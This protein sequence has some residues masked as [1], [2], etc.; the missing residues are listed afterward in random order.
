MKDIYKFHK[1]G[2]SVVTTDTTAKAIMLQRGI[3]DRLRKRSP[4]DTLSFCIDDNHPTHWLYCA[5]VMD[6]PDPPENGYM[7][8]AWPKAEFDLSFVRAAIAKQLGM[9]EA[10]ITGA[11]EVPRKSSS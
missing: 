11:F 6:H 9:L 7:V 4:S 1:S 10:E 8:I 2:V 5:L 3:L